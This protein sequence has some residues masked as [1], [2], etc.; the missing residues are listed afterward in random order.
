MAHA[1]ITGASGGI[2]LCLAQRLAQRRHDLILV[3]RSKATLDEIAVKLSADFQ[4]KVEVIAADLSQADGPDMLFREVTRRQLEV[5]I[6]INNAGYGLWGP[7]ERADKAELLNMMYLNMQSLVNLTH[8]FI[9]DLRKHPRA[10]LMNVASTAAYQAVPTL[11]TYAATKS[12]VV[13]FTRGLR[14]ELKNTG[15]VVSCLSP[16]GTK[17]GFVERAGMQRLKERADKFSMEADDV[18]EIALRGMFSGRAE[19]IPGVTNKVSVWLVGLLPKSI[20]ERIAARLYKVA[21]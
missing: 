3:A 19:I 16:G 11:T 7:V 15:I 12:F 4:V 20:V 13:S 9:P 5:D 6:L 18:A 1:L 14:R 2:G 8:A 17:T 10:Y 21:Q